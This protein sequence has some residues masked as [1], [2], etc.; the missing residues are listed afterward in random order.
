MT[1]SV[2]RM[3]RAARLVAARAALSTAAGVASGGPVR[4]SAIAAPKETWSAAAFLHAGVALAVVGAATILALVVF[5]VPAPVFLAV[6]GVVTALLVLTGV[7]ALA[8]GRGLVGRGLLAWAGLGWGLVVASAAY[9]LQLT[10][11]VP[12]LWLVWTLG[13]LVLGV[14]AAGAVETALAGL[15]ASVWVALASLVGESLLP[16]VVVL[17]VLFAFPML[18]RPSRLVGASSAVLTLTLAVAVALRWHGPAPAVPLAVLTALATAGLL[19]L[20]AARLPLEASTSLPPAGCPSYGISVV[21][22]AVA[23]VAVTLLPLQAVLD[24]L[25]ADVAGVPESAAR[26]LLL[27]AGVLMVAVVLPGRRLPGRRMGGRRLPGR[28]RAGS[29]IP[30]TLWVAGAITATAALL[31]PDRLADALRVL[32]A[33]AVM[34]YG[35]WVTRRARQPHLVGGLALV[36][37]GAA[38]LVV[39]APPIVIAAAVLAVGGYAVYLAQRVAAGTGPPP[40]QVY[41]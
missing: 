35:A 20:L 18:A 7:R 24:A 40:V 5:V 4:A 2:A 13:V 1:Q 38:L 21:T 29:T 11:L 3:N 25:R 34:G 37:L 16:A 9:L 10:G 30:L 27:P 23:L 39:G 15:L 32:T 33:V 31:V 19:R 12:H 8:A 22:G 28:R 6:F 26:A 36:A 41:Q 17:A 14:V